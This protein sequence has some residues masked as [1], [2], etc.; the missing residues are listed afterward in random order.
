MWLLK[1]K[2]LYE[3]TRKEKVEEKYYY[4]NKKDELTLKKYVNIACGECLIK[5][6]GKMIRLNDKKIISIEKI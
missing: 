1:I 3:T 4:I 5:E 6:E 2:V